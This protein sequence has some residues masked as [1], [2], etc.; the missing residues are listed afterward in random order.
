MSGGVFVVKD[1][2]TLVAMKPTS[3]ASEEI[4]QNLLA[5]F[6]ALLSGVRVT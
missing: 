2:E 3:F 4:F 6:P 1:A 5:Q